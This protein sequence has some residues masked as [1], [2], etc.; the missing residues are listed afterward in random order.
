MREKDDLS[1]INLKEIYAEKISRIKTTPTTT[2]SV[3]LDLY[4]AYNLIAFHH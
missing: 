1:R 2:C 4:I 3:L